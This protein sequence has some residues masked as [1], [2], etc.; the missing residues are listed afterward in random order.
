MRT[1][2]GTINEVAKQ[3]CQS[4]IY[5]ALA[6]EDLKNSEAGEILGVA[7]YDLLHIK[8]REHWGKVSTMAW[9]KV[10]A[11]VNSGQTLREYAVKHGKFM[12]EKVGS[13]P[14]IVLIEVPTMKD[15]KLAYKNSEGEELAPAPVPAPENTIHD[16][17][18]IK[19]LHEGKR[20]FREE[21]ISMS[22]FN[23]VTREHREQVV[24]LLAERSDLEKRIAELENNVPEIVSGKPMDQPDE[25]RAVAIDLEINIL[26]NGKK[27]SLS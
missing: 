4:R 11:W 15:G 13:M 27:F 12:P 23:Q 17:L 3:N 2:A 8:N 9:N 24:K 6:K 25:H 14:S 22:Y 16:D 19:P 10:L 7:V 26:I 20:E 5:I 1:K 21:T 18:A